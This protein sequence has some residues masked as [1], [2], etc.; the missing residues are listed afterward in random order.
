M[1]THAERGDPPRHQLAHRRFIVND[2]TEARR[3]YLWVLGVAT[4]GAILRRRES[5]LKVTL[6]DLRGFT[7]SS[8]DIFPSCSNFRADTL[9][10]GESRSVKC[11]IMAS[12][13]HLCVQ[14]HTANPLVLSRVE[15]V[16]RL[17]ANHVVE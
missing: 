10:G 15:P 16:S 12:F 6:G 5:D 17:T 8:F 3:S 2:Q 1:G 11:A 14:S 9:R 13:A 7:R 4:F